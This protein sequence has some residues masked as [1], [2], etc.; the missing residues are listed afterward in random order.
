M[1]LPMA[2]P[3]A[4]K[5]GQSWILKDRIDRKGESSPNPPGFYQQTHLEADL[6]LK[7]MSKRK[8]QD[9]HSQAEAV[10][11]NAAHMVSIR[12]GSMTNE[13]LSTKPAFI[14]AGILIL[15]GI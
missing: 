8:R 14:S 6:G 11:Y 7:S 4:S 5:T 1:P 10:K 2:D 3:Q 13:C 12:K 15:Q 9:S